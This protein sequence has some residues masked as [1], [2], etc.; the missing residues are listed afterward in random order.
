MRGRNSLS[1]VPIMLVS[2]KLGEPFPRIFNTRCH[3]TIGSEVFNR[4]TDRKALRAFYDATGGARWKQ[5]RGW[6]ENVD[7]LSAWF[8]VSVNASGRVTAVIVTDNNLN[9]ACRAFSCFFRRRFYGHLKARH[10]T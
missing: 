4:D 8:N 7:D 3:I 2:L 10:P 9:G 1:S 6:K 5:N